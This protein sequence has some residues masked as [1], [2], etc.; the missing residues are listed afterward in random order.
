MHSNKSVIYLSMSS[1]GLLHRGGGGGVVVVVVG[2][3]E[4]TGVRGDVRWSAV[5]GERER[6]ESECGSEA[7][8][9]SGTSHSEE[10]S[11][12]GDRRGDCQCGQCVSLLRGVDAGAACFMSLVER[13]S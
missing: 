9:L 12:L 2:A 11:N 13:M 5:V 7:T 3:T 8:D 10:E 4:A 6:I 1:V